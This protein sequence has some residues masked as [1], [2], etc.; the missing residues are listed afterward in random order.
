[1][2]I[3]VLLLGIL[4]IPAA[5]TLPSQDFHSPVIVSPYS[6]TIK[7]VQVGTKSTPQP[8]T[9]MNTGTGVVHISDV[10]VI[11]NFSQTNDC[12]MPPAGLAHN[13][14]C[15]IQV[16]FDPKEVGITSGTL[17]ITDDIPGGPLTVM[18]SGSGAL[19]TSQIEIAPSSLRFDVQ[20]QGSAGQPQTAMVS[21]PGKR[22]AQI[23]SITV[24]GDFTI[25]PSST[26]NTLGEMLAPGASCTVV[27]TFSPLGS[28]ERT[29]EVTIRD[30]AEGSPQ[31]ISLSGMGQ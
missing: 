2:R 7:D 14:T 25:M 9:V 6:L 13:E 27:V 30:D 17:A 28:G 12:P 3:V 31:K 5:V 1:M 8:V 19:G 16:F 24:S 11:G 4:L 26:C 10:A 21:N 22:T 23:A 29:G 18:I 20:A 15:T